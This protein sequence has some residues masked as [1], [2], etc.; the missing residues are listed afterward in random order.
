MAVTQHSVKL[1]AY[2][3][4]DL[5]KTS[6]TRG[7]VIFDTT[8]VTLRVMDGAKAGGFP[9]LRADLSN[10]T[11]QIPITVSATPP[12]KPI[13]GTVWLNT[14]NGG[15]YVY[16]VDPNGSQWIQP[17]SP[18]YS[19]TTAQ[20]YIL[21]QAST[22]TL[23]G[24][25]VDG[26]TIQSNNGIISAAN[27]TASVSI[28]APSNPVAG[29]LWL[30]STN[31]SLYVYANGAWV[32]PATAVTGGGS[33]YTL[34]AATTSSLG[35][36]I[37]DGTTILISPSGIISV[38]GANSYTLPTAT[39]GSL[40]GVIV[41]GTSVTI[42]SGGVISVNFAGYV[43]STSLTSTLSSYVTSTSLTSTL[44][45]YV[46]STSLTSTLTNYAT[47]SSVSSAIA[48]SAYSLPTASPTQLGGVKV[49]NTTI[50]I[51]GGVITATVAALTYGSFA[52]VSTTTATLTN[53]SSATATVTMGKGYILQ[54]IQ[55]SAG[56]WVTVYSSTSA[57]SNDSTR[58]IT[59]DPTPGSG[60]IA[61]AITTTAT[62]TYF[63]PAV[64]GYNNDGTVTTNAYLKI[65]NNSGSSAAI[66]V[67][68][69][70][71]RLA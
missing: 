46:T 42:N 64:F 52:T 66:T 15:L 51:T 6:Y 4:I 70:Y 37:A 43:T 29:S 5:A 39:T 58:S 19:N 20:T 23:G 38:T 14:T 32:Q 67:T 7:D 13:N 9:L 2:D 60:V 44:S 3:A 49:D 59:T 17:S 24:V 40:G 68:L 54:S 30:D 10:L 36:V 45:S 25:Y 53:A 31:D 71:L 22:T 33:T 55:V 56:A 57:Q 41:D 69:T 16:Y 12:A 18:N 28:N 34:P 11:G 62:T 8:N 26:V 48:G 35:G 27:S 65:Y 50:T 63:S 61:E 1:V 47:N 21:P